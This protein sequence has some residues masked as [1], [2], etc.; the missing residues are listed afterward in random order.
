MQILR[1]KTI[2]TKRNTLKL[3]AV[4]IVVFTFVIYFARVPMTNSYFTYQSNEY[5]Y[6]IDQ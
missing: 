3:I 6:Q 4:L 2:N 1:A 5:D